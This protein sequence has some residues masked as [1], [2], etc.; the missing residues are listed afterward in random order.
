MFLSS[1]WE[2]PSRA[3]RKFPLP[4][5]PGR[6][7]APAMTAP[8]AIGPVRP[9]YDLLD[10]AEERIRALSYRYDGPIPELE[11]RGAER[12]L[13]AR[14]EAARRPAGLVACLRA[15]V[16]SLEARVELH[17]RV[18]LKYVR[19]ACELRRAGQDPRPRLD[20]AHHEKAMVRLIVH[21]F[22]QAKAL[23]AATERV[24]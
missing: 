4:R 21:K 24:A 3:P 9:G 17:R 14:R 13:A 15:D 2:T 12:N 19:W 16:S 18:W 11:R 6:D 22:G 23:L 7:E 8:A 1:F 10:G 5:L 20:A